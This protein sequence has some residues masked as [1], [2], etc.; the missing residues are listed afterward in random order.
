MKE[1]SVTY[2]YSEKCRTTVK[3][4]SQADAEQKIYDFLCDNHNSLKND[5]QE[6]DFD[7]INE[8]EG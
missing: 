4:E 3:A 8:S 2:V 5:V 1:Y 6:R 7:I